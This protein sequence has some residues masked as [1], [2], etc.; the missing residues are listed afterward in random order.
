MVH[1]QVAVTDSCAAG[2]RAVLTTRT[3][4]MTNQTRLRSEPAL[5]VVAVHMQ[6]GF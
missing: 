1:Y 2:S 6:S 4:I 5:L 3:L